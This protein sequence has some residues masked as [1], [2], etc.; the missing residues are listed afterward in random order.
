MDKTEILT[1][2]KKLANGTDP[3]DNTYFPSDRKTIQAISYAIGVLEHT[4]SSEQ[5]ARRDRTRFA[6]LPENTGKPW[7]EHEDTL[8]LTEF[9]NGMS[10]DEIATKHH[11]TPTSIRMRLVKHGK[12]ASEPPSK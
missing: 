11:R 6:G 12:L 8:L 1:I 9:E 4:R 3:T 2:L 7:N 5:T 10:V